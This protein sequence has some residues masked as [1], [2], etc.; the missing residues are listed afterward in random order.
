M[1]NQIYA[2]TDTSRRNPSDCV[3]SLLSGQPVIIGTTTGGHHMSG[4]SMDTAANVANS[5]PTILFGGSFALTVTAKSGLSPSVNA[6]INPGDPIYADGG[7]LDTASNMTT[8]FTLDANSGAAFF[9]NLD[10]TGPA[11]TA[12]TT[13]V[14]TVVLPRGM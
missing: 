12:G 10:P 3:S 8:G 2:G 14:V 11:L 7:T 4:V 1:I 6:V 5:L 13:A 9:G